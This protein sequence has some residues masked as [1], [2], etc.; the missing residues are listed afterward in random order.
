M[1][2]W[3]T[4][5]TYSG[6]MEPRVDPELPERVAR[7]I[8]TGAYRMQ[9][10]KPVLLDWQTVRDSMK[11]NGSATVWCRLN[12]PN[13]PNLMPE[14]ALTKYYP[15]D[16]P[17][18]PEHVEPPVLVPSQ[19]KTDLQATATAFSALLDNPYWDLF[20]ARFRQLS[21]EDLKTRP[22]YELAAKIRDKLGELISGS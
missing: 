16:I 5:V 17:P 9:A 22:A 15:G 12:I 7:R 6:A 1:S 18:I 13:N 19:Y 14:T 10:G 8:I 4:R 21:F 20:V 3:V 11:A 2:G